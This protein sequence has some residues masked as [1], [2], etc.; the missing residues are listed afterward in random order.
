[1]LFQEESSDGSSSVM[2]SPSVPL[3][4]ACEK[5]KRWRIRKKREKR[6]NLS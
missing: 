6:T 3:R 5:N 4:V 1:M 2:A